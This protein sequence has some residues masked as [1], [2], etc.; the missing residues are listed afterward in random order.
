MKHSEQ[1]VGSHY[2]KGRHRFDGCH[3]R[4]CLIIGAGIGIIPGPT[5]L[6]VNTGGNLGNLSF[7]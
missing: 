3:R 4:Q 5:A 7:V 2:Q 6:G 1:G